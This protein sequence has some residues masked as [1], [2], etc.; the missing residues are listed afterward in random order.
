MSISWPHVANVTILYIVKTILTNVNLY[1]TR[2][3]W[4]FLDIYMQ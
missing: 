3:Y 1:G 4:N 2:Y